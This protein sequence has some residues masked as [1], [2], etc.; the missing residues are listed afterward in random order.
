MKRA[1]FR[2]QV[3]AT[4]AVLKA[5]G[6]RATTPAPRP[7]QVQLPYS[8]AGLKTEQNADSDC[9]S[10]ADMRD[11]GME[12]SA[13]IQRPSEVHGRSTMQSVTA[14]WVQAAIVSAGKSDD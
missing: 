12:S 1:G 6:S 2:E 5:S 11:L 10:E 3:N 9:D 14:V 8:S 7:A 4:S 13:G